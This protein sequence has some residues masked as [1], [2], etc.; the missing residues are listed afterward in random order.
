MRGLLS[1]FAAVMILFSMGMGTLAHATEALGCVEEESSLS[2]SAADMHGDLQPG[3]ADH[4]LPHHHGGCHGH[5]VGT[6]G[7]RVAFDGTA[8]TRDRLT[9]PPVQRLSAVEPARTL[10]PPIA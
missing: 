8:A 3:D 2:I 10:R 9:I 1:F 4:G 5:H 6:A 7:S